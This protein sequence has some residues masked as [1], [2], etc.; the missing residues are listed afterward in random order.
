MVIGDTVVRKSYDKDIT[1]KPLKP[2]E[3]NPVSRTFG[4]YADHYAGMKKRKWGT[5]S[6]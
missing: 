5:V 1:F 4:A 6:Y 2:H 3:W